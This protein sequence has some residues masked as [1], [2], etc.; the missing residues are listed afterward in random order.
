MITKNNIEKSTY[1]DFI[2]IKEILSEYT[3]RAYVVGGALRDTILGIKVHDLDIEVYDIDIDKFSKIMQYIGAKGVGKSFFVYKYNNI[4][5]SLARIEKKSGK[6]HKAFEVRIT[7][8]EKEASRRRDFTMNALMYHIY[9]KELLDFW[10]GKKDIKNKIIKIVDTE[11][12]KEDSLRVLRA[13]QFSAR[14]GFKC[15]KDS[16]CVMQEIKLDD[17]SKDRIFW[18]FEKLFQ[19]KYLQFGFYYLV[20]LGIMKKL[21]D[22]DLKCEDFFKICK[23]FI[24][25]QFGFEK[26][27][28][29]YYFLYIIS[30]I[31]NID[32]FTLL[33]KLNTPKIYEKFY[34]LQPKL[35]LAP[36]DKELLEIALK[37]PVKMYL[38][39]YIPAVKNRAKELGIYYKKFKTD[40]NVKDIIKEG[41]KGADI[42][43][44]IKKRE[45]KYINNFLSSKF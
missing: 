38:L 30:Q 3:K 23:V 5:I 15:D 11:S 32:I 6:G 7:G 26:E 17:L 36:N 13:V 25:Y 19:A 24:K 12:F 16:I 18:E 20:K 37:I 41:F 22:I 45:L 29:R 43:K 35:S 39:N 21:F 28:Y 10:G 4:D 31:L 1:K 44:E 9:K 2:Y 8:N 27:F 42:S 40:I 33:Q 34:K 14:F